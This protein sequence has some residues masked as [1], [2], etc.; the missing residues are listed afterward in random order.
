MEF[1]L[2]S[3]PLPALADAALKGSGV[4]CAVLW[5]VSVSDF[6]QRGKDLV[7]ASRVRQEEGTAELM[8]AQEDERTS[9]LAAAQLTAD[10]EELLQVTLTRRPCRRHTPPGSSP[11]GR[12]WCGSALSL[13]RKLEALASSRREGSS[14]PPWVSPVT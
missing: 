4:T 2:G 14:R 12:P 1:A 3:R 11:A 13:R 6:I 5:L 10:P 9:L 8:L 7:Q